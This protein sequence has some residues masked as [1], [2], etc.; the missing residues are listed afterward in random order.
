MNFVV[1]FL[2]D[3][4]RPTFLSTS[5]HDIYVDFVSSFFFFAEFCVEFFV[6]SFAGFPKITLG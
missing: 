1:N 4:N 5:F 6:E 3:V 2:F